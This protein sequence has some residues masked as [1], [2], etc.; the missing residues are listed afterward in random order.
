M[1]AREEATGVLFGDLAPADFGRA[2]EPL[3]DRFSDNPSPLAQLLR[4]F[5]DA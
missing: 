2:R 3:P 5:P 4:D 1:A